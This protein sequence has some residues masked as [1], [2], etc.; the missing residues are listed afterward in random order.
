MMPV[1]VCGLTWYVMGVMHESACPGVSHIV[2]K[3]GK[4][5]CGE[6]NVES[7]K[8]LGLSKSNGV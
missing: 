5:V 8:N 6:G 1:S 3:V 7:T 4:N 2:V